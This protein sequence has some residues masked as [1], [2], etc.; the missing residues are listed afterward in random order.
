MDV[1]YE[2][3]ITAEDPMAEAI[4]NIIDIGNANAV[5]RITCE[6]TGL[7]GRI[8]FSVGAFVVGAKINFSNEVG[9][10]ALRKLLAIT[11]GNYAILDPGRQIPQ[12]LNQTLWIRGSALRPLLPDLPESADGLIDGNPNVIKRGGQVSTGLQDRTV[13]QELSGL[14]SG[15]LQGKLRQFDV[16]TWKTIISLVFVLVAAITVVLIY[17]YGE[18]I[19]QSMFHKH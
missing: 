12:E 19:Y 10:P 18:P 9:Y 14:G 2:G 16:A 13:H 11:K 4:Q 5:L 17:L 8:G 7:Q 1:I 15:T 6:E 3:K